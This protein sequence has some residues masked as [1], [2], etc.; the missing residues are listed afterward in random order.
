MPYSPNKQSFNVK[1]AFKIGEK[2]P[3]S[4]AIKKLPIL[5]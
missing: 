4:K 1:L 5:L 3:N 2:V